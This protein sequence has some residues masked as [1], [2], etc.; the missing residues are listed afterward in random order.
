MSYRILQRSRRS[1]VLGAAAVVA[2]LAGGLLIAVPGAAS[3]A[4]SGFG[5]DFDGDGYHDLATA[6]PGAVASGEGK[7]GAVV[8]HYGSSSGIKAS[9]RTITT[10][11]SSGVPGTPEAND[12][13]GTELAHGDLNNDGYGDLVVGTP[14]EDVDGDTDGGTVTILWGGSSGLSGGTTISDPNVSGHDRFGQSLAVGDFTGDGRTDLAVGSTGKD[15]WIFKGGFTKSGGAAGTLRLDTEIESGAYP[16]G[17]VQLAAGDFDG[18]RTDDLVVA[19]AGGNYVYL[20]ASSGPTPQTEVGNGFAGALTVADFDLDGHDDLVVGNDFV[21]VLDGTAKGGYV[22]VFPGGPAGVDTTRGAVFSQ[23]TEGVPGADESNDSFGGALAA[24]DVNGDDFPDLAVGANFETIG[25]AEQAGNV[26][27][28]RGGSSGLTA[29]GAVSLN[30]GTPDVPGA[31]ESS[32]LFGSTVHLADHNGDDRA[33]LSVG[34]PGENSD[35]GSV[36]ALRGSA[37]GI[38]ASGSVSFTGPTVGIGDS[39]KDPVYGKT[40][41][42]S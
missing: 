15:V 10:Q 28:L 26:W 30:Q 27:V 36:W 2:A 3:A 34:A 23:A 35:D 32:D 17:A 31:N 13:F 5:D 7:A 20:G 18:D 11:S 14:L 42:G 22:T 21:G 19:S 39:G 29:N 4:P 8:V 37:S 38:T 41:S 1:S 33:D 12:R 25:E 24:G 16:D 6:A 40:M 9:N